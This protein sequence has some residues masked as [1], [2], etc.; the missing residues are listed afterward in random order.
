M[1]LGCSTRFAKSSLQA[2]L[3][4][5]PEASKLKK[6]NFLIK[7]VARELMGGRA[8]LLPRTKS[9]SFLFCFFSKRLAS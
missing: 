8:L 9:F 4:W 7:G 3:A 6:V 2:W 5:P 1:C